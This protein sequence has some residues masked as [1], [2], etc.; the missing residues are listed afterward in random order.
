MVITDTKISMPSK[1]YPKRSFG[2]QIFHLATLALSA[3]D[4]CAEFRIFLGKKSWQRIRKT[5]LS[6]QYAAGLPDALFNQKYQI[7][8]ILEC[9]GMEEDGLMYGHLVYFTGI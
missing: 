5:E 7:G 8:Y 1:I 9:L 4:F 6:S 3:T 2:M